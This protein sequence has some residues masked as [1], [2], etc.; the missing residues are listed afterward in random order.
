MKTTLEKRT[1]YVL[2]MNLVSLIAVVVVSIAVTDYATLSFPAATAASVAVYFLL[3]HY[4][5]VMVY[6]M[7][8]L[9]LL[10]IGGAL[11]ETIPPTESE[12]EK[13]EDSK[14]TL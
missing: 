4:L 6:M 8:Y 12:H 9:Y 1:S 14:S 2:L 7:Q 5:L 13:S 3:F 10:V 11:E